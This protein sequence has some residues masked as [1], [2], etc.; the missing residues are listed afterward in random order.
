MGFV[1]NSIFGSKSVVL[2]DERAN[3]DW[4]FL[5]AH[6]GTQGELIFTGHDLGDGVSSLMGYGE[7]EWTFTIAA[8]DISK[9]TAAL[10]VRG[11]FGTPWGRSRR[12]LR[13]L[14][15]WFSGGNASQLGPFL[16]K[17]DI[18]YLLWNR[19]GD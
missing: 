6:I 5:S 2:R 3:G 7:Y 16:K 8:I 14:R 1:A 17:H 13:T 15:R 18:P 10:N 19:V 9:L 11:V 12:L 4:R